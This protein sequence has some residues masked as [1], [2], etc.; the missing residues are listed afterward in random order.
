MTNIP[1]ELLRTLVTV[2]DLRSFTKAAQALGITQPAVSAQI[3]RVQML[4]GGD[5]F[6]RSAPGVTL[7][8]KGVLVV[9][10]AR[11][12]LSL[13]DQILNL[14][15]GRPTSQTLRVGI[16][17]DFAGARIPWTLANFRLKWPDVR[18]NVQCGNF[19]SLLRDVRQGEIDLV[20]GVSATEP[21]LPAR[22]QWT[23]EAVW[24]RSEATEIDLSGPVPLVSYG[25]G[26]AYHSAAISALYQAGR[27]CEHVFVASSIVS[28]SVAVTAGLGVTV[29]ARGRID[30]S[31]FLRTD[32]AIWEDA[33]LPKLPRLVFGIYAGEDD[34][35]R[36][37]DELANDIVAALRPE[38]YSDEQTNAPVRPAFS[39][40]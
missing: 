16:P 5:L 28:I 8:E 38:E 37:I 12:L 4:L 30:R 29:L 31:P 9:N 15:G 40:A 20:V 2:V 6:D 14:S 36:V 33:P 3:K 27:D 17:G 39:A 35:R 7:T 22:H 1:T 26:C 24:V 18:F 25:E 11:R 13:N 23:D 34:D 19:D 21:E 32:L 10:H